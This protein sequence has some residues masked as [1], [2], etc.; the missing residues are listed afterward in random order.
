MLMELWNL[1]EIAVDDQNKYY[2]V[3]SL[4]STS[5]DEVLGHGLLAMDVID[6]VIIFEFIESENPI[7]STFSK[8]STI[9]H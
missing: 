6:Q 9:S 4:I 5:S 1:M 7:Y 2:H 3:T 8:F